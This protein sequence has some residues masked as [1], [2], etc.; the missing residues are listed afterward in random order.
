M[1][2]TLAAL[3]PGKRYGILSSLVVPRPIA[4]LTTLNESGSVNAAPF[5]Y[6]NLMGDDP[7]LCVLGIGRR[8]DGGMKDT[9][10]N[11]RRSRDFVINIV[12]EENAPA[13]NLCATEFPEGISEVEALGLATEPSVH[14]KPPRLTISPAHI[15]GREM[16]TLL[17]GNTQVVIGELLAVHIRDEFLDG[18]KLRVQTAKMGIVGRMQG[19][20]EGG[21]TRTEDKFDLKRLTYEEWQARP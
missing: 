4:W 3:S 6:F 5:S 11:L 21:Y 1:H 14:V 9:F 15:E 12:T 8:P 10:R 20:L 13:M 7:P 19:G 2:L 17:I 18:E 16:Q